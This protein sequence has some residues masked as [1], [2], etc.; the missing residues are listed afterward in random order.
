ML[1]R[2]KENKGMEGGVPTKK[3]KGERRRRAEER[4]K[5][6][7]TVDAANRRLQTEDSMTREGVE[8]ATAQ[9]NTADTN[10]S[11]NASAN[12]SKNANRFMALENLL[13]K[14]DNSPATWADD[15]MEGQEETM[16]PS[17]SNIPSL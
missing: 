17:I 4:V 8:D 6:A 11:A 7:E 10:T 12:T 13:N 3:R 16:R 14:Q 2:E 9:V 15:E 5:E 1:A